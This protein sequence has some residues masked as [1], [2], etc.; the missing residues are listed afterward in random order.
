MSIV[1]KEHVES[2]QLMSFGFVP[3]AC[4]RYLNVKVGTKLVI[5]LDN[6]LYQAKY[7]GMSYEFDRD[8][9]YIPTTHI[10]LNVATIGKVEISLSNVDK[11]YESMEHFKCDISMSNKLANIKLNE[12]IAEILNDDFTLKDGRFYR[13][14]WNGI[15]AVQT[16]IKT[17]NILRYDGEDFYFKTIDIDGTYATI[18]ECNEYNEPKL[19]GFEDEDEEENSIEIIVLSVS[20]NLVVKAKFDRNTDSLIKIWSERS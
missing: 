3:K 6:K 10:H 15:K 12:V 17:S 20:A 8:M 2:V 11:L 16:E 13:Y 9:M 1:C 14:R 7:L 18:D 5:E 19:I 4:I